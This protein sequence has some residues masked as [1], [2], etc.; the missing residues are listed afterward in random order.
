MLRDLAALGVSY[1]KTFRTASCNSSSAIGSMGGALRSLARILASG[2]TCWSRVRVERSKTD[3]RGR[4]ADTASVSHRDKA[5]S[6]A[7]YF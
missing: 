1:T 7:R 4:V 3:R 5:G 2:F 6:P